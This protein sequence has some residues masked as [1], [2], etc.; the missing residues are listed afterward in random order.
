MTIETI[1]CGVGHLGMPHKYLSH[2]LLISQRR[3]PVVIQ[4]YRHA[5]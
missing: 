3:D 4:N 1:G 2:V 5:L